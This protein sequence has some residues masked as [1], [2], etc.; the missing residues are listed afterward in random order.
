MTNQK[1]AP[2]KIDHDT[3]LA[4]AIQGGRKDIF[5]ELVKRYEQVLYNFVFRIYGHVCD[6]ENVTQNELDVNTRKLSKKYP[7][8]CRSCWSCP[9]TLQRTA[10]LYALS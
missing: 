8:H 1:K 10:A 7:D 5:Q 3:G 6:A 2:K 4:P 9:V